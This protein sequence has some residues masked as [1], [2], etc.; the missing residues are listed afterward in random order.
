MRFAYVLF[1]CLLS[2][3]ATAQQGYRRFAFGGG[4]ALA[5]S[6]SDLQ[7]SGRDLMLWAGADL[8][9]THYF[10]LGIELQ[11]GKLR[12]T[13]GDRSFRLFENQF[14]A[15]EIYGKIHLGEL[16]TTT[17]GYRLDRDSFAQRV[18]KGIYLGSGGGVLISDQKK[19]ER[20]APP[21]L[22]YLYRGVDKNKELYIPLMAGAEFQPFRESRFFLALQFQRNLLLGDNMDGYYI[23]GSSPDVFSS[24]GLGLK[25]TFGRFTI[26]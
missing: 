3:A 10:N 17:G 19:I 20:R 4:A 8:Y 16:L 1:C 6:E 21:G 5:N 25:Y 9:L 2:L 24:L 13:D 23:G 11:R 18:L 12:G 7:S 22:E 14:S 26:D 15:V